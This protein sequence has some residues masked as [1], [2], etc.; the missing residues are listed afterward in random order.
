MR[1]LHYTTY[2]ETHTFVRVDEVG[3]VMTIAHTAANAE[4]V[5]RPRIF[6]WGSPTTRRIPFRFGS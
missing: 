5:A 6:S 4:P 2:P 3:Q 1:V